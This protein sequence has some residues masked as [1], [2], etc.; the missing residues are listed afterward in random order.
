MS[1]NKHKDEDIYRQIA[2]S[3]QQQ[4]G[5]QL[6]RQRQLLE[7]APPSEQWPTQRMDAVVRDKTRGNRRRKVIRLTAAVAACF[8]LVVLAPLMVRL[9]STQQNDA[10]KENQAEGIMEIAPL[11]FTL[12]DNLSVAATEQDQGMTIYYLD[13]TQKD[14]VV[15]QLESTETAELQTEGLVEIELEGQRVYAAATDSYNLLTFE[16]DE[17]VYTLTCAH[18]I[19]TL[20]GICMSLF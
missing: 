3:Y 5:E 19:N 10:A 20:T 7:Q 2:Q 13:D 12:P 1:M 8:L 6:H 18:D 16:Y 11:S 15:M 17:T 9:F 14:P 4:S